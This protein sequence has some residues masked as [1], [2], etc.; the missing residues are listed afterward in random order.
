MPKFKRFNRQDPSVRRHGP[1]KRRV[2]Y[3]EAIERVLLNTKDEWLSAVE[4]SEKANFFISSHW[5]QL[6]CYSVG[7]ILRIYEAKNIIKSKRI[8][9]TAPKQYRVID[10]GK[11]IL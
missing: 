7:S 2:V 6:N 4:I 8:I 5:T 10:R 3:K 11:L 1:K 9:S